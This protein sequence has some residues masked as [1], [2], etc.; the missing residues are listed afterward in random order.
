M[1]EYKLQTSDGGLTETGG[2]QFS[3]ERTGSRFSFV[4][5]DKEQDNHQV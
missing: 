5:T 2:C 4:L 3:A 1:N